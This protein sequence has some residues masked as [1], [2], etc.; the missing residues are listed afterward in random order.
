[1]GGVLVDERVV[2]EQMSIH[3]RMRAP[4]FRIVDIEPN[5]IRRSGLVYNGEGMI[6]MAKAVGKAK[7]LPFTGSPALVAI[8]VKITRYR[9]MT[10]TI[11]IARKVPMVV[12]KVSV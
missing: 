8:Q 6:V 5:L 12:S 1:M 10:D 9:T 3:I 11:N 7:Q 4:D 2:R